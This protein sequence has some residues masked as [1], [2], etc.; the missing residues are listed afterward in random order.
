MKKLFLTLSLVL[1][2]VFAFAACDSGDN[3]GDTPHTHA[4]G[5]WETTKEATRTEDGIKERVCAC[6]EKESE[7]IPMTGSVGLDYTINIAENGKY[8]I[9]TGIGTCTDNKIIIPAFVSD[10]EVSCIAKEAFLGCTGI[11]EIVL[12][13]TITRI[14]ASAFSGC[15]SLTSITFGGT[16]AQWQS[17]SKGG[18]WNYGTPTIT[19]KCT[20]GNITE[21]YS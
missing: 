2:L 12:P 7:A 20:D 9:V 17:V 15:T 14:D 18:D 13:K 19:V 8:C 21:T 11:T 6:G 3:G 5:E 10:Y 16:K 1:M 4:Y